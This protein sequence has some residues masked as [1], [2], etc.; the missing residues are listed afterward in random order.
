M[1]TIILLLIV[2]AFYDFLR[3][4]DHLEED[5]DDDCDEVDG[6]IEIEH[7]IEAEPITVEPIEVPVASKPIKKRQRQRR[8]KKTN[9]SVT[10]DYYGNTVK[11]LEFNIAPTQ[12]NWTFERGCKYKEEFKTY[13]LAE[14]AIKRMKRVKKSD[15][16]LRPYLCTE[17]NKFHNGHEPKNMDK[18]REN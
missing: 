15:R 8:K 13:E 12:R 14:T 16:P 6:H 18:L 17:C 7:Q 10:G 3:D 4:L 9:N 2:L 5:V 11:K 1:N